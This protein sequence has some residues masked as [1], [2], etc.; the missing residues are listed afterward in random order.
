MKKGTLIINVPFFILERLTAGSD[1]VVFDYI[2]NVSTILYAKI[3]F[4]V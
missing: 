1:L 4:F 3:H 2:P